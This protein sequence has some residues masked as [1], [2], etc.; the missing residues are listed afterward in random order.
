MDEYMIPE[1]TTDYM[2]MASSHGLD[3]LLP[4]DPSCF[5]GMQLACD[6][7]QHRYAVYGTIPLSKIVFDA[8]TDMMTDD[9]EKKLALKMIKKTKFRF[10]KAKVGQY[11][12]N[13]AIIPNPI[14]DPW[15]GKKFDCEKED[16]T[17]EI[18]VCQT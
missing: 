8:F 7:N 17:L 14:L 2:F 11:K 15:S 10:P 3:S 12:H 5:N 1:E 6:F 9:E 18:K 4:V 13:M 16:V